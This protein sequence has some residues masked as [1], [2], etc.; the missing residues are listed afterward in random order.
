MYLLRRPANAIKA[1]R[2]HRVDDQYDRQLN[3]PSSECCYVYLG[4]QLPG[5]NRFPDGGS[6]NKFSWLAKTNRMSYLC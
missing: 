2:R 1:A 3:T 6:F 4:G 5:N